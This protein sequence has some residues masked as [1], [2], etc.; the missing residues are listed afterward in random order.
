MYSLVLKDLLIQ[1]KTL[2]FG[3]V[4]F[5]FFAFAMQGVGIVIFPASLTAFTYMAVVTACAYDDK[6]KT[7]VMLNSLP[8]KRS[9]IVMAKYISVFFFIAVG[10]IL[11]FIVSAVVGLTGL[12]VSAY[13]VTAEGFVGALLSI[14]LINCIYFPFFFKLGYTK[15][16]FI[17]LLLFFSFFFGMT[18]LLQYIVKYKD[19]VWVQNIANFFTALSDMQ[20]IVLIIGSIAVMILLSLAVSLKIYSNKDL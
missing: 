3:I 5:V 17:N 6:N 11:Y 1:K 8:L 20:V 18:W 10:L 4:Y 2:L 13:R 16:R 9:N 12:P 19:T 14:S 15:S 7:D